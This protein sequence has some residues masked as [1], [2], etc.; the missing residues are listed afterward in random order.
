MREPLKVGDKM[1]ARPSAECAFGKEWMPET[2]EAQY[3]TVVYIHPT[4]RYYVLEFRAA[5]TGQTWRETRYFDNRLAT[6][7][8]GKRV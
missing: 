6:T 2:L 1:L 5:I 4:K 8:K 3:A 7:Q